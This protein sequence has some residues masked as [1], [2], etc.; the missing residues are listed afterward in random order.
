VH[1]LEIKVLTST[2]FEQVYCSSSGYY[3]VYTAI[4]IC[5]GYWQGR[6]GISSVV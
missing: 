1:Q 5:S 4:G 3:S 6:N 2:C